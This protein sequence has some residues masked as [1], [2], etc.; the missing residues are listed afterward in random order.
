MNGRIPRAFID[1]LIS[2]ADIVEVVGRRVALK[3]AG[4]NYKGLC[5]FHD[6]KTPSFNVN[7]ARGIFK[8]FGC[9]AGGNAIDFLMKFDHLPFPEAIEALADLLGVPMPERE[10]DS[11]EPV[12]APLLNV[13]DKADQYFRAQLREHQ[14]A[15]DYL[16]GRGIDGPT[17][18]RFGLGYA[19]E[20]WSGLLDTFEAGRRSELLQA[21]L[22]R[23][24]EQGREYDYF[25]NRIMFP[26]R[27]ARGRTLGFGGRVMGDGEP[28]YLNSPETPVFEK[29]RTLYGIYEARRSPGRIHDVLVVEGYMDVIAI[30]QH[31]A[32]HALA[33]L[34]TATTR[35]HVQQLT[36]L[37]DEVIFCFDGDAAGRRAAWRALET[38]LP[39]GGGNVSIRFMLLPGS[40]DP[41]SVL[42]ERGVEVFIKHKSG[43]ATLSAFFL[44]ELRERHDL[45]DADGRARLLNEA[46]ALIA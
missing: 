44:A 42:R 12:R 10:T 33:T 1:D 45:G 22:I 8:C 7:P 17:A 40:L 6:E 5:P 2:R 16:K 13:L 15:I 14:P 20:G 27:D 11:H 38:C 21:G 30:A 37:A 18:A 36:R 46:K 25:R 29:G 34:G 26:I 35:E 39:F 32:G 28:K 9:D 19:P 3:K 31:D 23:R 4:S 43:A 41:D 24:N